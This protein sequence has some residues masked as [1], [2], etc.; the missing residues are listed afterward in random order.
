M[1][2]FRAHIRIALIGLL[3]ALLTSNNTAHALDLDRKLPAISPPSASF[4]GGDSQQSPMRVLP[5]K[6]RAPKSDD[7]IV[8]PILPPQAAA[9]NT[10][11][12]IYNKGALAYHQKDFA[13]ALKY[14]VKA[15]E[16]GVMGATWR[17]A[18]MYRLEPV[19][20]NIQSRNITSAICM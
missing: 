2:I 9:D 4:S 15:S 7:V 14:W 6:L 8:K 1:R 16:M 3:F 5:N 11:T 19:M 18:H 12:G 13:N 17:I 20:D 10:P